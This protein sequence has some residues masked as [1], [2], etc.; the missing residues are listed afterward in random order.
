MK[1]KILYIITKGNFGGAQ[2]YVYDLATTLPKDQFEVVVAHG[3]GETLGNKLREAGIRIIKL[4][5]SQR[6]INPIKDILAF[7]EILK[8]IREEKPNIVHLN[9]SKV[10]LL[11]ALACRILNLLK[12]KTYHLKTI[13][14]GHG[15]AFTEDRNFLSKA[16]LAILHW[17]TLLMSHATIAVS[18]RTADQI[19]HFPFVKKKIKT[20]HNGI[21]SF[22]L[23]PQ[24]EARKALAPQITEQTWIGTISELHKNKGLDFLIEAF[25]PLTEKYVN[26]ALV[27]VGAGE[28]EEKLKELVEKFGI[29][30]KVVFTGFMPEARK[31]LQA[32]DIMTLTSRT[33]NLPYALLEAGFAERAVVS[34]WI[35]GIP[36][37]VTNTESGVL[38]KVGNVEE[39]TKAL[40]DLIEN[41]GLRIQYG[42]SL[43]ET[44]MNKFTLSKMLSE[45][46]AL[47]K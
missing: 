11:G 29:A 8:V 23:L 20:I 14:T 2:R 42:K 36:E 15:W 38:T 18:Q 28:E 3:D 7:F 47:Y 31:Y 44:I 25:A 4:K 26:V 17:K 21:E 22:S 30:N 39:I 13:F 16:F 41:V 40:D 37:I 46:I 10:G 5:S 45:T 9:S 1:R 32:F 34:S 27:I 43:K 19:S 24:G 12:P 6:N 33:E 35:G